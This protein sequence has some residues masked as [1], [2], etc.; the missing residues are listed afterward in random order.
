MKKTFLLLLMTAFVFLCF[1]PNAT[2]ADARILIGSTGAASSHYAYWVAVGEAIKKYA[3]GISPTVVETGGTNDNADRL[4]RK[5]VDIGLGNIE[6]AFNAYRGEAK[7]KGKPNPEMRWLWSY[8]K[9]PMDIV[10]R[11]DSGVNSIYDLSGKKFCAGA[12]GSGGEILLQ[13]VF[14]ILGIKPDYYRGGYDDATAALEDRQIVGMAKWAAGEDVG[15]ALII[16][17]SST[18]KL[19]WL[20]LSDKDFQKV[21]KSLTYILSFSHPPN[22]YKDQTYEVT[23]IG[24]TSCC[25]TTSNLSPDLGYRIAKAAYEGKKIQE[26][27]FPAFKKIDMFR[28]A[29]QYASVPFHVGTV[30]IC[31]ELGIQ[32]PKHLMPP[33]YK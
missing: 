14:E 29:V 24:T 26:E 30:K 11:V 5:Q 13:Q 19:R 25:F 15:D 18:T 12:R 32:V 2:A 33:E 16:R 31:N 6:T 9:I 17:I 23:S 28:L 27:S 21:Q 7:W 8:T 4:I 20:S 10:V 22:V 1:K 3:P